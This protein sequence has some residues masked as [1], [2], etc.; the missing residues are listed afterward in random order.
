MHLAVRG[1]LFFT[2]L[3]RLII[4]FGNLEKNGMPL[5]SETAPV[6]K[7]DVTSKKIEHDRLARLD[8]VLRIT[9][10]S[11]STW[12]RGIAAGKFPAPIKLT[13]GTS[14]WRVSSILELINH[15]EAIESNK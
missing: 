8:E 12:Y 6:A 4:N 1:L 13:E 5:I 14:R 10:V 3:C 11:K 2:I 15:A 7:L 9:G